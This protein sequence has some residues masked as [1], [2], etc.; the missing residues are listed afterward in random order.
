M[1]ALTFEYPAGYVFID[2]RASLQNS[3]IYD[4]GEIVLLGGKE[5][6]NINTKQSV[7]KTIT[8]RNK[9]VRA[10]RYDKHIKHG[11]YKNPTLQL[12][13]IG[14][15]AF[16]RV[17]NA[18]NY[19]TNHQYSNTIAS[20][21]IMN[22]G[23]LLCKFMYK[24]DFCTVSPDSI[25]D[26]KLILPQNSEDIIRQAMRIKSEIDAVKRQKHIDALRFVENMLDIVA[27]KAKVPQRVKPI[28]FIG[29]THE[30]RFAPNGDSGVCVCQKEHQIKCKHRGFL[31]FQYEEP[32]ESW[33]LP[34]SNYIHAQPFT[35]YVDWINSDCDIMLGGVKWW[36]MDEIEKLVNDGE[37]IKIDNRFYIVSEK[38]L[39]KH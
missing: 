5:C 17:K 19:L 24:D 18:E 30:L 6:F 33:D 20:L 23:W 8:K 39:I 27:G 26:K 7:A 10:L 38:T 36:S 3:A 29:V 1:V 28:N 16:L 9:I 34:E 37:F 35:P 2:D 4:N 25:L 31:V 14:G 13:I 11:W 22:D 12:C 21:R 32:L 15:S